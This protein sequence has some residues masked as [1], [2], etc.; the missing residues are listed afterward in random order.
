MKV[1]CLK[2]K[3]QKPTQKQTDALV[4]Q[5][6]RAFT[7]AGFVTGVHSYGPTS[8]DIGLHMKCFQVDTDK[9]GFNARMNYSNPWGGERGPK[10]GF[11][12]TSL[13]TWDQRVEFNDILNDILD[14][15][16]AT[17]RIVSGPFVIRTVDE[18]AYC[19]RQWG[20]VRSSFPAEIIPLTAEMIAQAKETRRRIARERAKIKRERDAGFIQVFI[21]GELH[22]ELSPTEYAEYRLQMST[23]D[24]HTHTTRLVRNSGTVSFTDAQGEFKT[25]RMLTLVNG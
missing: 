24:F 14:R 7:A 25:K 12:K 16:K 4:K 19:E 13:P 17:A 2:I 5:I 23:G 10:V 1:S 20:T 18:G 6:K 3:G 9:L 22:A 11:K 8:M 21:K 15:A